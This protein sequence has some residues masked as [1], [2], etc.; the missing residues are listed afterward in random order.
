ML[1]IPVGVGAPCSAC[2][3][4]IGSHEW[5]T[6]PLRWQD[7]SW[8]PINVGLLSTPQCAS[9]ENMAFPQLDLDLLYSPVSGLDK[10]FWEG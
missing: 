2:L 7:D 3:Q 8:L 5:A 1:L 6:I 9:H 4:D 10:P